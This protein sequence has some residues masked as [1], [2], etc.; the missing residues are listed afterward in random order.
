MNF[1]W[2]FKFTT[3]FNTGTC[4]EESNYGPSDWESNLRPVESSAIFDQRLPKACWRIQFT[5]SGN[6]DEKKGIS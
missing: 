2:Q 5:Y 1:T 4:S 6:A 3:F